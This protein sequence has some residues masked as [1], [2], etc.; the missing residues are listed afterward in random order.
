MGQLHSMIQQFCQLVGPM[1]L[2][3]MFVSFY[4]CMT[5]PNIAMEELKAEI[6]LDSRAA[7]KALVPKLAFF[8]CN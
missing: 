1:F 7:L 6:E 4:V 2:F 8:N 5:N 3:P